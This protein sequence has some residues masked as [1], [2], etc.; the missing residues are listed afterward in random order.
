MQLTFTFPR[1]PPR[2]PQRPLQC[3]PPRVFERYVDNMLGRG[4][5]SREISMG[6]RALARWKD[7][8]EFL[9]IFDSLAKRMARD[10]ALRR[11]TVGEVTGALWACGK[12]YATEDMEGGVGWD[13]EGKPSY[14]KAAEKMARKMKGMR[15]GNARSYA[16]GM[17]GINKVGVGNG[18][19]AELLGM[20]RRLASR[21][22]SGGCSS[23]AWS[24]AKMWEREGSG[25]R[26]EHAALAGEV[27]ER[28]G[29]RAL[30][31]SVVGKLT[32]KDAS[33]LM[34]SYAKVGRGWRPE[35]EGF[36][37]AMLDVI[38]GDL[39]ECSAQTMAVAIW[40]AER[41]GKLSKRARKVFDDWNEKVM[42][43]KGIVG[44][45]GEVAGRDGAEIAFFVEE[46]DDCDVEDAG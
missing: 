5:G 23:V 38:E 34:W 37:G 18:A 11:A 25:V 19:G 17:W 46:G 39:R 36:M 28:I 24:I 26:S 44:V 45:E 13:L 7:G 30:H 6:M 41:N 1:P 2:L 31:K 35:D 8:A 42:G 3:P 32:T 21:L 10:D 22:D 16:M 33:M 12:V 29:K 14:V 27:M 15:V 40:A 20:G 43:I 4:M 9:G